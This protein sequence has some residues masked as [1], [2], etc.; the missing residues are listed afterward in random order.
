MS[1]RSMLSFNGGWLSCLF[2]VLPEHPRIGSCALVVLADYLLVA[3]DEVL[4]HAEG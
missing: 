4:W 1:T 2:A 3:L